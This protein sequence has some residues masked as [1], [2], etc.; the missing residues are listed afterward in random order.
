MKDNCSF[1]VVVFFFPNRK[2][3]FQDIVDLQN[4]GE[5]KIKGEFVDLA[6]IGDWS[7]STTMDNSELDERNKGLG[8]VTICH[9]SDWVL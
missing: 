1:I 3:G 2:G 6:R 7:N 9:Y 5:L 8:Q 4:E